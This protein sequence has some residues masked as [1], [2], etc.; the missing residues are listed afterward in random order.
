MR[1]FCL[2]FVRIKHRP[3]TDSIWMM[4]LVRSPSAFPHSAR[5]FYPRREPGGTESR[6]PRRVPGDRVRAET[7]PPAS[8]RIGALPGTLARGVARAPPPLARPLRR[9]LITTLLRNET[10][11]GRSSCSHRCQMG[12]APVAHPRNRKRWASSRRRRR[13]LFTLQVF[14]RQMTFANENRVKTKRL[15]IEITEWAGETCALETML[16]PAKFALSSY[17]AALALPK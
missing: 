7:R 9:P 2:S 4:T 11:Q 8:D 12:C 16:P 13:I 10:R 14:N 3:A 17:C 5:P 1:V 15:T 6:A